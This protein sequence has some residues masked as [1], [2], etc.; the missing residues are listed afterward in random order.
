MRHVAIGTKQEDNKKRKQ[1]NSVRQN[2]SAKTLTFSASAADAGVPKR[3]FVRACI[4]SCR[5]CSVQP[6]LSGDE[7]CDDEQRQRHRPVDR[8]EEGDDRKR[9][10]EQQ[11][12]PAEPAA[13]NESNH[14]LCLRVGQI[15][16]A[17]RDDLLTP[18]RISAHNA[19]LRMSMMRHATTAS[20]QRAS[21]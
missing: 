1:N 11:K 9:A 20:G 5:D 7:N 18:R 19:S 3:L 4:A 8:G 16:A 14:G 13:T 12:K 15:A 17:K 2:E 6:V 21:P 10:R